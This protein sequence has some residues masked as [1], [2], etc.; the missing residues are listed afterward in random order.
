MPT[1]Q[2]KRWSAFHTSS[3]FL[4]LHERTG[5]HSRAADTTGNKPFVA[6]WGSLWHDYLAVTVQCEIDVRE[7]KSAVTLNSIHLELTKLS[8][9]L[10]HGPP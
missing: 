7:A 9:Q 6:L 8:D 4:Y 1:I 10:G 2:G 5:W 3:G